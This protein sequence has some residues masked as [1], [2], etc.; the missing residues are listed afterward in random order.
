MASVGSVR[1]AATAASR[2]RLRAALDTGQPRRTSLAPVSIV[3][4]CQGGA[5]KGA[6]DRTIGKVRRALALT[7]P[8]PSRKSSVTSRYSFSATSGVV[9]RDGY[10]P[11]CARTR[12][13]ASHR[14]MACALSAP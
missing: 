7:S 10:C 4:P 14:P 9:S 6:P 8:P 12:N 11:T 1:F 3:Y 5:V 2:R 13:R